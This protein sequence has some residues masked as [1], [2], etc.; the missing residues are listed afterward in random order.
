VQLATSS[1]NTYQASLTNEDG[2]TLGLGLASVNGVAPATV[3]GQVSGNAETFP[4]VLSGTGGQVDYALRQIVSGLDAR[5]TFHSAPQSERVI[6]N[7]NPDERATTTQ[8]ASGIEVQQQVQLCDGCAPA[9]A[10]EYRVGAP[11]LR[12]SS[13]DVTGVVQSGNVGAALST[14]GPGPTQ[15]ILSLDQ[16]WLADPA[17][18]YPVALDVPVVTAY[19]GALT[20]TLARLAMWD[21]PALR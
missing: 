13:T 20:G 9:E 18:V 3:G 2:I 10:V 17:R 6:F 1:G 11:L 14:S 19:A 4:A 8:D 21:P 5:I 16:S 15:I 7:L 12:D